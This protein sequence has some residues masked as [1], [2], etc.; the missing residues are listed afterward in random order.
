MEMTIEKK[1]KKREYQKKYQKEYWKNNKERLKELNKKWLEEHP[2]Y[3][4][5][6]YKLHKEHMMFTQKM[7][8]EFNDKKDIVYKFVDDKGTNIYV[9]STTYIGT[10]LGNHLV[11]NSH[12]KMSAEE[13]VEEWGLDKILYKDFSEYNLSRDDLY[14]I[15]SYYKS[16]EKEL[17]KT[18]EVHFDEDK[19][20]RSKEELQLL[21]D[22]LDFIEF[23]KLERYLN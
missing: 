5:N 3:W 2:D 6:Y 15:E 14:Y 11:G 21:S 22:S 12:L 18:S 9:G 13:M 4:K 8:R 20:T 7:W 19:L 1:E 17:M 16:K 10:R 23:N